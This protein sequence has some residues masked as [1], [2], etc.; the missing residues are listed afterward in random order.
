MRKR[1]RWADRQC[2]STIAQRS[3]RV[4]SPQGHADTMPAPSADLTIDLTALDID[5]LL[6]EWRWRVPKDY[7]PIQMTKFGDS[8]FADA[9]EQVHMPDL[10][11]G[12]LQEVAPSI[13]AY[14]ELDTPD[15]QNEWFLD[16]LV[17]RCAESDV[18]LDSSQ[19]YGWEVHP[20][21]GGKLTIDNIK[22]YSL[23]VYQSIMGQIFRQYQN[24]KLGDP[25]PFIKIN[26]R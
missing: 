23:R 13:G 12:T 2:C 9:K 7:R 1:T 10:I 5:D 21:L 6:R 20:L 25:L 26:P 4:H 22:V 18:L 16:S 3:W 24:H 17:F 11:E 8:F 15:K 14:K 19:C